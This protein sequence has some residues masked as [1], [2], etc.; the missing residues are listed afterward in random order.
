MVNKAKSF[1]RE[2][3]KKLRDPELAYEYKK[4]AEEC[5]KAMLRV[6]EQDIEESKEIN[7]KTFCN[8]VIASLKEYCRQSR[9]LQRKG[10]AK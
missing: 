3:L 1:K 7:A 5:S 8:M 4:A 2:L 6:A 10:M 9:K